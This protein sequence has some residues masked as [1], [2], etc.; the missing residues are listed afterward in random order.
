KPLERQAAR[1]LGV[2]V[3][4]DAVA[5]ERRPVLGELRFGRARGM[6][7]VGGGAGRGHECR[8]GSNVER[9]R[10]SALAAACDDAFG[11]FGAADAAASVDATAVSGTGR[12]C[13]RMSSRSKAATCSGG[14]TSV[15]RAVGKFGS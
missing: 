11:A 1:A 6:Q 14:T 9:A 5:L 3:T 2:V 15:S 4:V 10:H 7:E 8:A 13:A 12:P